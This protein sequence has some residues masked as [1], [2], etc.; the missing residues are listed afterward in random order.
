MLL[1]N[2]SLQHGKLSATVSIL[3]PLQ[4]KKRKKKMCTKILLAGLIIFEVY[5]LW[6]Q[7]WVFNTAEYWRG[8]PFDIEFYSSF[9]SSSLS[10]YFYPSLEYSSS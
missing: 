10:L 2:L 9:F 3:F 8:W 7:S 6:N 1:E 4:I 5:C